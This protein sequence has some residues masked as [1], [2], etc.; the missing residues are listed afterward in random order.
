MDWSPPDSSVHGDSPGKNTGVCCHALLQGIFPTQGAN[1]GLLH[2]KQILYHLSHQGSPQEPYMPQITYS[3]FIRDIKER[4]WICS[5]WVSTK[6]KAHIIPSKSILRTT[7]PFT[8]LFLSNS[9]SSVFI[10]GPALISQL[11]FIFPL[12]HS[13]LFSPIY[14]PVYFIS[15]V[16]KA[17]Y[18]CFC[19]FISENFK[20][21]Q[22]CIFAI[23]KV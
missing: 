16:V 3:P 6:L 2:C 5:Y 15:C 7:Q 22:T 13:I 18:W 12:L 23:N 14:L 4:L 17:I 21:L 8:T 19:N 10:L 20:I 9:F 1:P 11:P